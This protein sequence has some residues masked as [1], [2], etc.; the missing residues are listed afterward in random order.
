MVTPLTD[1]K[2]GKADGGGRGTRRRTRIST[3]EAVCRLKAWEKPAALSVCSR[4][5]RAQ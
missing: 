2:K 1:Y 4:G 5:C 3:Q